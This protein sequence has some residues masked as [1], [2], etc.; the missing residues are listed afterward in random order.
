LRTKSAGCDSS[1][2]LQR[3]RPKDLRQEAEELAAQTVD[4]DVWAATS[5]WEEL[6]RKQRKINGEWW[7]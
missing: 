5:I 7:G 2:D 3:R 4:G 1:V 6:D